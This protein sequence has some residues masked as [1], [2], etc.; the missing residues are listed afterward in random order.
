M[1]KMNFD[2]LVAKAEQRKR[3]KL[4]VKLFDLPGAGALAFHK[5][6]DG[7]LLDYY[8]KLA[9]TTSAEAALALSDELIY[10]CCPDLQSTE[11]HAALGVKDPSDVVPA[12]L[13]IHERDVLGGKL[14]GWV[15]LMPD[16]AEETAKNG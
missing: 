15:G 10:D 5:P 4:E 1:E 2:A 7:A 8:G 6:G 9:E 16:K 13:E 11:L 14:L 12:L 3:S